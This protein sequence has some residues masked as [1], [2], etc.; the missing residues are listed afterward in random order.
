MRI[1]ILVEL[2][3]YVCNMLEDSDVRHNSSFF[4]CPGSYINWPIFKKPFYPNRHSFSWNRSLRG[5]N[6]SWLLFMLFLPLGQTTIIYF[7]LAFS[8]KVIQKQKYLQNRAVLLLN[9]AGGEERGAGLSSETRID[10]K[11][12]SQMD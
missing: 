6:L 5:E 1:L 8:L 2:H 7:L 3:D 10:R 12:G 11:N 9:M 4:L